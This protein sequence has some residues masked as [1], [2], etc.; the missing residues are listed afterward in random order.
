MRRKNTKTHVL[1]GDCLDFLPEFVNERIKVSSIVCDPPYGIDFLKAKWDHPDNIAFQ[2]DVWR[3]CLDLLE[4]GGHLVAFGGTRTY[5]RLA[6]AIEDAG[7][8]IRDQLAWVYGTG[9][10][11]SLNVSKAIDKAARGVPTGGADPTSPNHGKYKGMHGNGY[12]TADGTFYTAAS[13]PPNTG[14]YGGGIGRKEVI[15]R[16][17]NV[18]DPIKNAEHLKRW[19]Q[20]YGGCGDIVA[21]ATVEARQW[22]GWGTALKPAWEPIV[23]ARKPFPGTVAANV[24]ARSTG[25]MNIDGCRVEGLMDG[26]WGTSNATIELNDGVRKFNGSP[27]AREYRSEQHEAGRWPANFIHDGSDEVLETFG[28]GTASR[29]FYCAKTSKA[30]R[31]GS[32]HPTIKPLALMR[33]LVRLVTPPDGLVIDPSAGSGTTGE[34][35]Y[36]EGFSSILIEH[37]PESVRDIERRLNR[38]Q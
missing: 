17:P 33:W 32:K 34:A 31:N 8:E 11:K 20:G 19:Q 35:A 6:C 25:A 4:P 1:E 22:V 2:P 37:D 30:E 28:S 10:P 15:G 16:N 21:P 23:L 14:G 7:F 3:L 29:F 38:R 9:F 12:R 5:H 13:G 18:R 27:G 36:L 26:I 24:I